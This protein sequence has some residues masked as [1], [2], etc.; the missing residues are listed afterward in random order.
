M[1][2]KHS[3]RCKPH[4]S[5]VAWP[6]WV[7]YVYPAARWS[8]AAVK[9]VF[10]DVRC[11]LAATKMLYVVKKRS[12]LLRS[13]HFGHCEIVWVLSDGRA[14]VSPAHRLVGFFPAWYL[15][16]FQTRKHVIQRSMT[17]YDYDIWSSLEYILNIGNPAWYTCRFYPVFYFSSYLKFDVVLFPPDF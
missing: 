14:A 8:L 5:V 7:L 12:L 6:L 9:Y 4:F 1:G 13:R 10:F 16:Y 15:D 17:W 3:D 11:E 2:K